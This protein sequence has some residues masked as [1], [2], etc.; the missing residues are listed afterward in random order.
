MTKLPIATAAMDDTALTGIEFGYLLEYLHE[1]YGLAQQAVEGTLSELAQILGY[2]NIDSTTVIE[3]SD[4]K[5]LME[6]VGT[7]PA[8]RTE[9]HRFLA[10]K[11]AFQEVEDDNVQE[12]YQLQKLQEVLDLAAERSATIEQCGKRGG[13]NVVTMAKGTTI[14][15]KSMKGKVLWSSME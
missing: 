7:E 3:F 6:E 5:I 14:L 1:Q 2:H 13:W 8:T 10:A 12:F 9:F 4:T 11:G 15:F